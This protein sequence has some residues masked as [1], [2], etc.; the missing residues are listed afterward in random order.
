[1]KRQWTKPTHGASF[2][3]APS[4][5]SRYMFTHTQYTC[6]HISHN[7]LASQGTNLLGALSD[8]EALLVLARTPD[9]GKIELQALKVRRSINLRLGRA[10]HAVCDAQYTKQLEGGSRGHRPWPRGHASLLDALDSPYRARS[11]AGDGGPCRVSL[12]SENVLR[13]SFMSGLWPGA[14]LDYASRQA[15]LVTSDNELLVFHLPSGIATTTIAFAK[16]PAG[17]QCDDID[18]DWE[19][20]IVVCS[21]NG[22][23]WRFPLARPGNKPLHHV[24]RC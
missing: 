19:G 1:M 6:T 12:K 17:R 16:A 8:L 23:L 20:G 9:V 15:L 11:G 14:P 2:I 21:F 13:L 7:T 3:S 10:E 5:D 4:L 18:V 24:V 22:S